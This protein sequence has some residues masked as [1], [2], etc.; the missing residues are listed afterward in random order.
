MAPLKLSHWLWQTGGMWHGLL[1]S[2]YGWLYKIYL[3]VNKFVRRT[4]F[5]QFCSICIQDTVIKKHIC[6]TAS[7]IDWWT[8]EEVCSSIPLKWIPW[9]S[10]NILHWQK[11]WR[12]GHCKNSIDIVGLWKVKH[13]VYA[14][15]HRLDM[16]EKKM[17]CNK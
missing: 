8:V 9:T 7:M 5:Q 13:K 4:Y 10:G 17:Y 16:I 11:W 14:Y 1:Q 2:S 15:N 12:T 6:C 3:T